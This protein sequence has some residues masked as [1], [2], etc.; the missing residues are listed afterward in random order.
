MAPAPDRDK[1]LE[2]ALAQIDKNFGKG[3]VMRL[4]DEGRAP[5]ATIPT[6]AIALDVALGIGGLPRGRVVEIYGP[7]SSGKT[8]VA[9]HAVANAQRAGGIAAFID[10]EHALDP[11]YAKN[12]GVDTD[13]LLVSQPDTGEQALEIAD[14]LIRSGALDILVIDSV[15]ALVPR[16]EIE[17]EMGDSH[18]G[19]QARLMSQALRKMTG[20][21]S[22]SGT[23]A[24]FINQLREKIG[25]MF[26]SPETTT[27]GKALKFYASIRLDVRRIETL[28][29][30]GEPVGNRTRVKVVKNKCVAEGT[31]V[32]DPATGLTHRVEDIV[33][34]RLPVH[35]VAT[36]KRGELHVKAVR[37]W[38][39]QGEQDVIG[40]R[41]KDT[42]IWVTPDHKVLTEQGWQRADSLAA[43]DRMVRPR[44]FLGFGSARPMSSED[45]RMLG[46]L[47]GDGYVGGKTPIHFINIAEPIIEDAVRIAA[48]LGCKATY[49]SD[50]Y[51]IDF[52]HRA[53]EKN[54]L[55]QLCREFG[56]WQTLAYDKKLAPVFFDADISA[57]I[58]AN[59]IFG[60]FE[61]DGHASREATGGIRVG[62][63]TTSEQLAQQIHWLLLRW[64]IGSAV[65]LRSDRV[66]SGGVIGDRKI[67][68]KR[69]T[70][71][72]RVS[73]IDNVSAFAEAIP[74]WGPRGNTLVGYLREAEGRYRGSQR[75]YLPDCVIEP[76][77][78][79]LRTR[80]TTPR[81]AA[82]VIGEHAGDPKLGMRA[83][84]GMPRIRR[85]RLERLAT[86]LD[87][88]FLR[89]ILVEQVWYSTIR[90]VLPQRRRR[91]FD[92]E[93]DELH[94][95][96]ADDVVVH[97]C[98]PPFKQ[99][100]FDIL[101]GKGISREGSLIDMG[102]D[103]G[104]LRKSGAW[105]TYEGDQLGQGKENARKFL[106][107]NP[108]VAD[109][110]E[111]RIKDKLGIG[112]KLDADETTAP[113]APVE[114]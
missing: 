95:F 93:V 85:D 64:G 28:K 5:I 63:T 53:G 33:D 66:G 111:K 112:A 105:Y 78:E 26:G 25:V 94:N 72:V 113:V 108:D 17:G 88:A 70:W 96:V 40:L 91:T 7:E 2:L 102:V 101:Y 52:S 54:D 3:S 65:Q 18:V 87:D 27:G 98:A 16:A 50:K 44:Q 47:I 15:A 83:V 58:V 35:V 51:S 103:Q 71:E 42:E 89:E 38:F 34:R 41:L 1:A 22:N 13:A 92:I 90:E 10:A 37:S 30:G 57:D 11:E 100:E 74:M 48:R 104:I 59:L 62:F 12:L 14:M 8:T 20:A 36:D 32:F 46:Y 68:A 73:G 23:T 24:I 80:G 29:D 99:A 55:L 9:L 97:N 60:L 75:N 84:L 61:T 67:M 81:L 82:D 49:K 77:L 31:R 107:E 45:A 6:G 56:I 106:L 79:H 4:G 19:L 110:V 86:G 39:D 43:G 21:M 69:P 114:F 76:V 109:E